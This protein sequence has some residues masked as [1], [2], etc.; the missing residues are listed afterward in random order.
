MLTTRGFTVA[1]L[2]TVIGIIGVL[3]SVGYAT[4]SPMRA[5][6]RDTQR[7]SDVAQLQIAFKLYRETYG[8]YPQ[9]AQPVTIGEGGALDTTLTTY[10]ARAL[11]DPNG[12][13]SENAYEYVYDESPNCS[14]S[15]NRSIV[16]AKTMELVQH[17]NWAQV[18]GG[19]EPG[20]NTY[21]VVLQ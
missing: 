16:Y 19:T 10:I 18:C 7:I 2:I 11:S 21:V 3:M 8:E 20:T 17:G 6:A 14:N 4:L 5:K 9:H 1:E 13:P 15:G 12:S